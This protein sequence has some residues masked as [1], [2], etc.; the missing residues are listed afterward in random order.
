MS[1]KMQNEKKQLN[2]YRLLAGSYEQNS[3]TK[4]Y[5]D[6]VTQEPRPVIEQYQAPRP[7]G[8]GKGKFDPET[9]V[10]SHLDLEARFNWPGMPKKF[11]RLHEDQRQ[12]VAAAKPAL[13]DY[14]DLRNRSQKDLL[15]FCDKY[16]LDVPEGKTSKDDLLAVIK[17][18]LGA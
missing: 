16:E 8:D 4:T 1:T 17:T 5:L 14:N 18:A 12:A 11:E 15:A 6:P 2:R 10:E 9:I 13:V 3:P 7:L